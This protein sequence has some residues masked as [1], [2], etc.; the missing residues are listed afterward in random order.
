[1]EANRYCYTDGGVFPNP[2]VGSHAFIVLDENR[3]I[4][5]QECDGE[6]NTTNNR[7]EMRAV[8]GAL[9]YAAEHPLDF[10]KI[11]TDSQYV[12]K[13]LTEWMSGWKRKGWVNSQKDP[14]VNKELWLE[15]DRVYS[16]LR[17]VKLEWVKG[18]AGN[19][20][21]ELVDQMCTAKR[22]ELT[23]ESAEKRAQRPLSFQSAPEPAAE[24]TCCTALSEH[25]QFNHHFRA[26]DIN[27][28]PFCG[29]GIVKAAVVQPFTLFS[30]H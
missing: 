12:L 6:H 20:Y 15:L 19:E 29:E 18:H 1:M 16:V 7:M 23:N 3:K 9:L 2:G 21:N 26:L 5:H 22:L 17:N 4:I 28:C 30:Q 14:V 8:Y 25:R 27:Y 11:I 13:G 10:F 24:A